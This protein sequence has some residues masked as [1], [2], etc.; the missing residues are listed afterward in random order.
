MLVRWH[1]ANIIFSK[2]CLQELTLSLL[3]ARKEIKS[4][5]PADIKREVLD[6]GEQVLHLKRQR[7]IQLA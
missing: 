2:E 3:S 6:E 7:N 1:S 4:S 5:L